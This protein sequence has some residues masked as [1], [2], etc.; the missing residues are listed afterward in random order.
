[1]TSEERVAY[2][3]E[4]LDDLRDR[5][6]HGTM[7]IGGEEAHLLWDATVDAFVSG[8]WVATLLCAQATCERVLAGLMSLQDLP[9]VGATLPKNWEERWGLGRI[10]GFIREKAL[11]PDPLLDEVQ[12]L[13][14][15]RKPFGHWRRPLDDG[16]VGRRVSD[17]VASGGWA[18]DPH[19]LTQ[20]LVAEDA[21]HA[22]RTALA[23]YYGNYFMS[24]F[25]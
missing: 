14:E 17:A 24:P 1:M 10:I 9:G 11:V 7:L 2:L 25:G 16:T 12:V 13:C 15:R 23:L 19:V 18:A 20:H 3:D 8:N 22:A 21:A 4:G 5:H 6:E